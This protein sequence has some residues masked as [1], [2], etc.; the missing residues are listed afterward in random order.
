MGVDISTSIVAGLM[1][2]GT[3]KAK[4]KGYDEYS[5]YYEGNEVVLVDSSSFII[6]KTVN[7]G[8]PQRTYSLVNDASKLEIPTEE[9]LASLFADIEKIA[10]KAKV[11]KPDLVGLWVVTSV[12]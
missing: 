8:S 11:W 7:A 1:V 10:R 6:G 9:E 4:L 2:K 3:P 5:D 12:F